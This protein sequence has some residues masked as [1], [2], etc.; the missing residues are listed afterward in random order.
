MGKDEKDNLKKTI[1]EL[2]EE[3]A[4]LKN[5]V[6][7]LKNQ[8]MQVNEQKNNPGPPLQRRP[9]SIKTRFP[10]FLVLLSW[11]LEKDI[12]VSTVKRHFLST[13]I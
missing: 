12:S 11:S 1:M 5:N 2:E 13:N 10:A 7:V 6:A 8:Q 3:K 4:Q 9:I